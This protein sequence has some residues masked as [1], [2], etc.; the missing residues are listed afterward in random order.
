L[1]K[2]FI[3]PS[4]NNFEILKKKHSSIKFSNNLILLDKHLPVEDVNF[5]LKDFRDGKDW[6]ITTKKRRDWKY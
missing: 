1:I 4:K 6:S 2:Y 5:N 3:E